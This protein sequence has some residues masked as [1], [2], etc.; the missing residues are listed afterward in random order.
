VAKF[1]F[2]NKNIRKAFALA[3][4]RKEIVDNIT[5]LG[6]EEATNLLSSSFGKPMAYFKDHDVEQARNFFRLG[7]KELGI[8]QLHELS[9]YYS[10]GDLN[11][12][13]AQTLQQQWKEALGVK[14]N[15]EH[16]EHKI[17][18]ER[19]RNRNYEL[20]QSFWMSQYNDPMGVLE[21]FKYKTNA[22]NYPGWENSDYIRLLEKTVFD[23]TPEE[24]LKTLAAA[25]ALFMEEMPLAP[26]YHWKTTFIIRDH[27]KYPAYERNGVVEV[28]RIS[29]KDE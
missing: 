2:N 28:T 22:K 1:P 29:F 10:H 26:L 25:E 21:R 4:N 14:I 8:G 3:I 9:Y 5:Q 24:R 12:R 17:F 15:L 18:L 23:P 13:L 20:A 27:L 11:H 6:E 7:L 16:S 19:L